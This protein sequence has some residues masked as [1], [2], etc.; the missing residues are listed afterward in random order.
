MSSEANLD[1]IHRMYEALNAQDLEAQEEFWTQDMIWHGPPGF[2]DIHGLEGFKNE[3]LKPFYAAF[4]DYHVKN[5][6]EVADETWVAATGF[7][8]ATHQ[9]EWLGISATGKPVKMRFSDFWLVKG[10]RLSENWVMV[11]HIDVLRQL[12]IE[13][14]EQ[15]KG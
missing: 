4:P 6:I 13:P 7:L 2:G 10:N 3:V 9:G 14:L 1:L 5:D 15:A 11:D 12:G 8:T